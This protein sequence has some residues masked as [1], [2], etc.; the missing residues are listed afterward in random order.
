MSARA[1]RRLIER[2]RAHQ[3]P[4]L[5]PYDAL[6]WG[7]CLTLAAPLALARGWDAAAVSIEHD[8]EPFAFPDALREDYARYVESRF[9][10]KG[11][12]HDGTKLMLV[13]N[14]AH[15]ADA[16]RLV[17]RTRAC[18]YS[19]VQFVRDVLAPDPDLRRRVLDEVVIGGVVRVPSS[20]CMHLVVVT[21][22]DRVLLAR[23]ALD[24]GYYPGAWA[25]TL[26]EQ[27]EVE[28]LD[29]AADGVL[30]RWIARALDEELSLGAGAFAPQD[31]RVLSAFL[32]CDIL[33]A[34]VCCHVR[35]ARAAGEVEAA[36]AARP[37]H[38]R[39][40]IEHAFV[41]HDALDAWLSRPR[42]TLHPAT[43]YRALLARVRHDGVEA[44][45]ARLGG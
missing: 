22:D 4:A 15:A 5:L 41:A 40:L 42:G 27:A 23:R 24:A 7:H 6:G 45:V 19:E 13:A 33:N 12:A 36:L 10:E 16:S 35:L 30:L 32:E 18:R 3:D 29:G 39:E 37:D 1:L 11:F 17:L 8:P 2:S 34:A 9:L 44:T 26:E 20:L 31:A 14:P 38:G 28:D 43:P 21:A 25:C